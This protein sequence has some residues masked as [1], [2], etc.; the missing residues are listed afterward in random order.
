MFRDA[1]D[2]V[3]LFMFAMMFDLSVTVLRRL[4]RA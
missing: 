1:A 4:R 3:T 2:F